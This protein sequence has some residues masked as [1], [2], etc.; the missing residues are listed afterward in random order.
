M[1]LDC[2]IAVIGG[3]PAGSM[4]ALTAARAGLNVAIFERVRHPR[5]HIGESFLP[6]TL[7][8]LRQ[9]GLEDRLHAVPRTRKMGASLMFPDDDAPTDF[10]FR[11]SFRGDEGEAFNLARAPFDAMLLEAARDAG[12][13]VH[14]NTA[15]RQVS[16]L[17]DGRCTL[18]TDHGTVQAR[19]VI[20]ASGQSCLIGRRAGLRA[21]I[22]GLDNV[23]CYGHY[24]GVH[25][26]EGDLGGMIVVVMFEEGWAWFIPLDQE[27]TSVGI[28]MRAAEARKA[29][30]P[31]TQLLDWAIARCPALQ[32]RMENAVS[33]VPHQT[34]ADFSYSCKPYCGPGFFLAGDA[35]VFLDPVFSTGV[36][37]G[38][39]TGTWAAESAGAFLRGE[40]PAAALR[41]D[42]TRRLASVSDLYTRFVTRFYTQ[43]FREV[44]MQRT[45]PLRVHCAVMSTLAADVFPKPAWRL[46][47]RMRLFDL[48]VYMQRWH[49]L[50]PETPAWSLLEAKPNG[51]AAPGAAAAGPASLE[52]ATA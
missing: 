22:K 30:V 17:T 9:I 1:D 2:D 26:R 29:G 45:G 14:E 50:S 23:A 42:Y 7:D 34:A 36:C 47:W 8:L 20:D 16:E 3:G 51:W 13:H 11:D 38:L 31:A 18:Q 4:A 19:F 15:I 5:F 35:A 39:M 48:F 44:F 46:R 6:Q 37:L 52:G 41:R 12:A 33:L 24:T 32:R 43:A 10:F 28:V 25:R 27:R 49:L 21:P 40:R